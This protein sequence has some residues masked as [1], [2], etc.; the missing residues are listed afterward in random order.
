MFQLVINQVLGWII[1]ASRGMWNNAELHGFASDLIN[2]VLLI[3]E[4]DTHTR[5]RVFVR[6]R[7]TPIGSYMAPKTMIRNNNDK[8]MILP[9]GWWSP[10]YGCHKWCKHNVMNHQK[11]RRRPSAKG[12]KPHDSNASTT[13]HQKRIEWKTRD[14]D[15]KQPTRKIKYANAKA[16]AQIHTIKRTIFGVHTWAYLVVK[17]S[18]MAVGAILIPYFLK[19]MRC[20]VL[21]FSLLRLRSFVSRRSIAAVTTGRFAVAAAVVVIIFVVCWHRLIGTAVLNFSL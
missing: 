14:R 16:R 19:L 18:S 10:G 21:F 12:S 8:T 6:A 3:T 17:C 5:A 20:V 9:I 13:E 11:R 7:L 2:L 1:S 15:R 4:I